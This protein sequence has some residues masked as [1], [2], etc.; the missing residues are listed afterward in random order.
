MNYVWGDDGVRKDVLETPHLV[1]LRMLGVDHLR[2]VGDL[3]ES[4]KDD[5]GRIGWG[6]SEVAH[7]VPVTAPSGLGIAVE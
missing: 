7:V 5:P 3:S 2:F 1:T 6:L 4:M